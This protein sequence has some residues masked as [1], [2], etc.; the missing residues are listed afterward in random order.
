MIAIRFQLFPYKTWSIVSA[1]SDAHSPP[2]LFHIASLSQYYY[3]GLVTSDVCGTP[4]STTVSII[5]SN[6][7]RSERNDRPTP[8]A[9]KSVLRHQRP[10]QPNFSFICTEPKSEYNFTH[11]HT[12]ALALTHSW[13][14][15]NLS[16]VGP[17]R[18][19]LDSQGLLV[20]TP[21]AP[22]SESTSSMLFCVCAVLG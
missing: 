4:V 1:V 8:Y 2:S 9:T 18:S 16:V 21:T 22:W 12:H 10:D 19:E 17:Q 5:F 14:G 6:T 13:I 15:R 3:S 20:H 7:V 11:T